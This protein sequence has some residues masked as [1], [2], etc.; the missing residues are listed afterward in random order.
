MTANIRRLLQVAL[1]EAEKRHIKSL[2]AGEGLT[3]RQA[4]LQA[5]QTWEAQLPSRAQP[6]LAADRPAD[7]DVQRPGRTKRAATP[8][9]DR[10]TTTRSRSSTPA[11]GQFPYLKAPSGNWLR[12]AGQLDWS[13]C[14]AA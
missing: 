10:H 6:V 8:G 13:K 3:L 2:A 12:R 9:A 11:R 5:F 4:I 14:P 1:S 7:A